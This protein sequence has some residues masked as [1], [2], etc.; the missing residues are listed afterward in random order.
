MLKKIYDQES[1]LGEQD[2]VQDI[3]AGKLLRNH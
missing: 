3:D 2:I 1:K